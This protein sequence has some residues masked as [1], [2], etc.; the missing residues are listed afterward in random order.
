MDDW[1]VDFSKLGTFS[2]VTAD[3]LLHAVN[4]HIA[5]YC[6][7]NSRDHAYWSYMLL[8][9]FQQ[10]YITEC[11]FHGH[12]LVNVVSAPFNLSKLPDSLTPGCV[13]QLRD[14]HRAKEIRDVTASIVDF[15]DMMAEV[16]DIRGSHTDHICA[17][18]DKL[19]GPGETDGD[20]TGDF[21]TLTWSS[22]A[23]AID[24]ECENLVVTVS[25]CTG[26][27]NLELVSTSDPFV[28]VILKQADGTEQEFR[29]AMVDSDL[30][31]KYKETFKFETNAAM[32]DAG[33][34]HEATLIFEVW[35][36][37]D[38]FIAVAHKLMGKI[39]FPLS[40]L[41]ADE[42]HACFQRSSRITNLKQRQA[43]A[44]PI[45]KGLV[46]R[47]Q[48]R[49]L[50]HN[51]QREEEGSTRTDVL[52][53][54]AH[55]DEA[56]CINVDCDEACSIGMLTWSSVTETSEHEQ[57]NW[58]VREKKEHLFVT[59]KE[60]EG[61][62]PGTMGVSPTEFKDLELPYIKVRLL[63]ANGTEQE[64]QTAAKD[65]GCYHER[66][67]FVI[68]TAMRT[69]GVHEAKLIFELWDEHNPNSIMGYTS[70]QLG[71]LNV[72]PRQTCSAQVCY[73]NVIKQSVR[74]S[75]NCTTLT[76]NKNDAVLKALS[77][78]VD[79]HAANMLEPMKLLTF[80]E[81][82]FFD[83]TIAKSGDPVHVPILKASELE[84]LF[85][86]HV[87]KALHAS[88]VE[89]AASLTAA[90]ADT[91]PAA[92]IAASLIDGFSVSGGR[93]GSYSDWITD[94]C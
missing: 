25:K 43:E 77:P 2:Y 35:D 13:V 72:A 89:L 88:T 18:T 87:V 9:A 58:F 34:I 49:V 64:F 48:L 8:H 51:W 5:E 92:A 7:I 84:E 19:N 86:Y 57:S 50:N 40:E 55:D 10:T 67:E 61:V 71:G 91:A 70:F 42:Q 73:D 33:C 47:G 31:P 39:S 4:A 20:E 68:D 82:N 81:V 83:Y 32:F 12:F 46:K 94:L 1:Q 24:Q 3:D 11:R 36:D 85:P 23:V 54:G 41:N 6:P 14:A 17:R 53:G 76:Q 38:V 78:I 66:F 30:N 93:Y 69:A 37:N 65:C 16:G 44:G 45:M 90:L 56:P 29:T 80:F 75:N 79:F 15:E 21:G 52:Q 74:I 63:Q 60:C 28:K 22:T 59:V 62:P 27:K 26:L